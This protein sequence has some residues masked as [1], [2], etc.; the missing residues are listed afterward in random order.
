MGTATG[1]PIG[2]AVLVVFAVAAFSTNCMA[3]ETAPA[4][5]AAVKTNAR[6][7]ARA[8]VGSRAGWRGYGANRWLIYLPPS[9]RNKHRASGVARRCMLAASDA[10][11]AIG[12]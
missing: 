4:D 8:W 12:W 9:A 10:A 3:S 5:P 11:A 1:I 6:E 7:S 2:L